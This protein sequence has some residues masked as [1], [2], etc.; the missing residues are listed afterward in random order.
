ME[1]K[2][3]NHADA[4]A[5][6]RRNSGQGKQEMTEP[7]TGD[8]PYEQGKRGVGPEKDGYSPSP[9]PDQG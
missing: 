3:G 8:R 4:P 7:G 9:G 5:R 6:V 2:Q 1:K